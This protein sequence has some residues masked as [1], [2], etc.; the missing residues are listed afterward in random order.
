MQLND[1]TTAAVLVTRD[2]DSN[3]ISSLKAGALIMPFSI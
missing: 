3:Q 1:K 2:I